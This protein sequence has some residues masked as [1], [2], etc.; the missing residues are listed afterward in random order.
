MSA[1]YRLARMLMVTTPVHKL[2]GS[3]APGVNPQQLSSFLASVRPTCSNPQ[4]RR[5]S[6]MLRP[7][8]QVVKRT[9]DA[10]V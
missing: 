6:D 5:S 2:F 3:A 8:R 10:D 1:I 4:E 7:S 9:S